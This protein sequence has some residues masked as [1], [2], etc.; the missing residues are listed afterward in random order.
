[1]MR[2][3]PGRYERD[4]AP[5]IWREVMAACDAYFG[6]GERAWAGDARAP[7]FTDEQVE[8][9]L[10]TWDGYRTDAGAMGWGGN[11]EKPFAYEFTALPLGIKRAVC[12]RVW[13]LCKEA[14]LWDDAEYMAGVRRR[15]REEAGLRED[16]T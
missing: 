3:L 1:M 4:L 14:G 16:L 7:E 13:V 2:I 11:R 8:R 12:Q 9:Q 10:A 15:R 5:A 6:R